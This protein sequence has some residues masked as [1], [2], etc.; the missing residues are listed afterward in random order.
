MGSDVIVKLKNR[1]ITLK[2]VTSIVID[3]LS[4]V[5][6]SFSFPQSPQMS[7]ESPQKSSK[8]QIFKTSIQWHRCWWWGSKYPHICLQ[9]SWIELL[10]GFYFIVIK[11]EGTILKFSMTLSLRVNFS[12]KRLTF[13]KVDFE[14]CLDS[15]FSDGIQWWLHF[16]LQ[17]R[18][19]FTA[20]LP[21]L[22]GVI[23][24]RLHYSHH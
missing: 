17:C 22:S 18:V 9:I 3:S 16:C 19:L 4:I 2:V 6:M 12:G 14:T 7:S 21:A 11:C 15:K 10:Q 20:P 1:S 24:S 5:K 13:W 8:S 23:P